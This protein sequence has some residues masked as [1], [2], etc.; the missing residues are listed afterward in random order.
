MNES[1]DVNTSYPTG[2]FYLHNR[3]A[4]MNKLHELVWAKISTKTIKENILKNQ[5]NVKDIKMYFGQGW[6]NCIGLCIW[7]IGQSLFSRAATYLLRAV[8]H[9]L[10]IFGNLDKYI[11]KFRKIYF[12][13]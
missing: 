10:Q 2:Y 12:K 1:F 9:L 5:E 11:L 6:A 4:I 7:K 8:A 3:M 13:I